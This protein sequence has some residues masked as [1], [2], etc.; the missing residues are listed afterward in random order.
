MNIVGQRVVFHL[1]REGREVLDGILS[2][3]G[4]FSALVLDVDGFGPVI[5]MPGPGSVRTE[6]IAAVTLRW[7]YIATMAYEHHQ[8]VVEKESRIGFA[9]H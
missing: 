8:R 1:S 4:S 9:S 7:G 3:N 5:R 2:E 6:S